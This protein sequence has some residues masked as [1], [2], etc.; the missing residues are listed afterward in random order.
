MSSHL[1]D[2][3]AEYTRCLADREA[4]RRAYD[5]R[6]DR[7]ANGRLAVFVLAVAFAA[8]AWWGGI[9]FGWLAL[10][11]AAFTG[12]V[13]WHEITS[14]AAARAD[15]A[16]EHYRK[17]LKRIDGTWPGR[18]K[19]HHFPLP[20]DHPYASD[21]DLFGEASLFELLCQAQTRAGEERLAGWMTGPQSAEAI[22]ARQEA[23]R[24]LV[25]RLDLRED[26]GR[27][28]AD[29]RRAL[30]GESL[31]RWAKR[32]A[33]LPQGWQRI[34]ALALSGAV[35]AALVL[36]VETGVAAPFLLLA[37]VQLVVFKF[38]VKPMLKIVSVA[39]E[40]ARELA[41]LAALLIRIERES[42]SSAALKAIQER[43]REGGQPVSA[44]IAQLE[45]L[46]YL[47]DLQGNQLF[48][49]VALILMWGVH[50]A[51]A[52]ENWRAR[53]GRHLPDWLEAVGEFEAL[54]SLAG[55]AYEHPNYPFPEVVEG[56]PSLAGEALVHP[57]LKPGACVANDVHLGDELRV[58]IVSGSN[59]SGKSTYLRV[60]GINVVLAQIG[61][62]V[63]A[64]SL[65]LTPFQIGAT[66]RVQDSIQGGVSRFYAE[67]RRLKAVADLIDEAF[68]VLFLLDEIL[69]GTNSHDRQ[70][71]AEALVKSFVERGAVGF[72]TT[73]DLAL[74]KAANAMGAAAK[75]VHFSDHLD[76]GELRF[77][78]TMHPGVVTHSNA[79]QLMANLGLLP[80]QG[81]GPAPTYPV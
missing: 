55:F 28:G 14:R 74:T 24:E 78:Y 39:E 41:V 61:A 60:V 38:V 30:R 53:W 81:D 29:V 42:F 50:V 66:L 7:I 1:H 12:L 8:G 6:F 20:E 18:G 13:V 46:V 65:R 58:T 59:M 73:H 23:V 32:S 62:P 72:V 11:G 45:R 27:L 10:P 34:G 40:P 25:D 75:N 63:A 68:P 44:R 21:L 52:M 35:V 80:A 16:A 77:D 48:A 54:L 37:A 43:L 79:L 2:P 4:A 56:P 26:L 70:I 36:L 64:R 9:S 5:L 57:L 51:F 33:R 15:A 67:L 71:G 49:P 31:A 47:Y 22:R 19:G 69:H 3:A 76:G 17:G